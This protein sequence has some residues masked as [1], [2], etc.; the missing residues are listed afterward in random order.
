[1]LKKMVVTVDIDYPKDITNITL[2]YMQQYADHIG[3]EFRIVSDQ[4]WPELP[5][6][7]EKFQLYDLDV[8]HITFID[9]DAL[10]NPLA[11]DFST[12][13]P[14]IMVFA[15]L[16]DGSDFTS[17]SPP[18]KHKV[19]VHSAFLA[20]H[21]CCKWLVEP[22]GDPLQYEKYVKNKNP[23]WQLDEYIMTLNLLKHG[24]NI[25]TTKYDFPNT[26]AHD[27]NYLTVD[28]KVQMLKQNEQIL[29]KKDRL[30][31]A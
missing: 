29:I 19:R 3:A 18:G 30:Q 25:L 22:H 24:G 28:Q 27:G 21:R 7:Q 1:M 26:I 31:Y 6:T 20:F 16:L 11:T 23:A 13:D 15:E 8:D 2:P 17:D 10:V 12:L 9:A 5:L 4:K 14:S